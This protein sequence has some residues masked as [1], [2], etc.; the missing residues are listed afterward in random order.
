MKPGPT[1][2]TVG[3]NPPLYHIPQLTLPMNT[4]LR[5][6][7][8]YP[9]G[10]WQ[11]VPPGNDDRL[12]DFYCFPT[13]HSTWGF[14]RRNDL[15]RYLS[16]YLLNFDPGGIVSSKFTGTV[17]FTPVTTTAPLNQFWGINKSISY[18]ASTTILTFTARIVDIGCSLEQLILT[19]LFD[20][21]N[22]HYNPNRR[23]QQIGNSD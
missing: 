14:Q 7:R 20:R 6:H 16:C 5:H 1:D 10:C 8:F 9:N 18:G 17:S 23:L 12:R 2:L 21:N 15:R 13:Y 19:W 3:K 4:V 22:P 11:L